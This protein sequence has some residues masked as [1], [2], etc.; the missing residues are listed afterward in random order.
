ME[1]QHSRSLGCPS[2]A[3]DKIGL[4]GNQMIWEDHEC[5]KSEGLQIPTVRGLKMPIVRGLRMPTVRGL[6]MN[7]VRGVRMPTMK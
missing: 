2:V 4:D 6:R 7:T 3:P 5:V 1:G